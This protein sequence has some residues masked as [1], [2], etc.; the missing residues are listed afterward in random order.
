MSAEESTREQRL[1]HGAG[2]LLHGVGPA[3]AAPGERWA[4][5]AARWFLA[6][7]AV[8]VVTTAVCLHP[9]LLIVLAAALTLAAFAASRQAEQEDEDDGDEPDDDPDDQDEEEDTEPVPLHPDDLA[10]IVRDL[11]AGTGVLLKTL[12]E[13]LASDVPDREWTTAGVRVALADAGIRVREGVR[14]PGVGN[15]AGVHR[16]DIPAPLSPAQGDPSPTVVVPGQPG[17]NNGNNT[18]VEDV[19]AARVIKDGADRWQDATVPTIARRTL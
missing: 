19:G 6:L 2:I 3:L 8:S 13:H 9:L 15:T 11:G 1:I 5:R 16:D 18:V 7:L 14:V 4:E 10:D 12:R 17:N